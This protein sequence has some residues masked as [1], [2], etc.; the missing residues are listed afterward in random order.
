M[1]NAGL[2]PPPLPPAGAGGDAVQLGP[3]LPFA[4]PNPQ[5]LPLPP[6]VGAGLLP[7]VGHFDYAG[8]KTHPSI[9]TMEITLQY[10]DFQET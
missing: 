5:Q 7:I 2:G 6:P 1:L 10:A 8:I 3:A 4:P 9:L